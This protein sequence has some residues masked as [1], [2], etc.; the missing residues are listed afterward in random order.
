MPLVTHTMCGM[1][2]SCTGGVLDSTSSD[3]NV[4]WIAVRTVVPTPSKGDILMG[5]GVDNRPVM[6]KFDDYGCQICKCDLPASHRR[7]TKFGTNF[8]RWF[9]G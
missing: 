7:V 2:L 6:G 4:V 9:W 5:P 1:L 3:C 8:G